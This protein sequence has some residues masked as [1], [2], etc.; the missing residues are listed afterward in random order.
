MPKPHYQNFVLIQQMLDLI[1]YLMV[2][3]RS[4]QKQFFLHPTQKE[5]LL[6]QHDTHGAKAIAPQRQK[7]LHLFR[8]Q[9]FHHL[10]LLRES[11]NLEDQDSVFGL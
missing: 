4:H 1:H 5:Y 9:Q 10:V 7:R 11:K 8:Q 6:V 2:L 3:Q